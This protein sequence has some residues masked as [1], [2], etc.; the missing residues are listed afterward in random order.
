MKIIYLSIILLLTF[1]CRDK[2][3][4]LPKNQLVGTWKLISQCVKNGTNPCN[5]E[6]LSA[7]KTVTITFTND[8]RYLESFKNTTA[9]KYGFLG[10]GGGYSLEG[11]QVRIVG[12]CMSSLGGRLYDY[13]LTSDNQLIFEVDYLGKFIYQKQ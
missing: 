7:D 5:E 1:S 10:C 2:D 6:I 12:F 3:A 13:T 4:E 11:K 9:N 8:D